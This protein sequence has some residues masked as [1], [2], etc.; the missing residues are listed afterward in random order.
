MYDLRKAVL[1]PRVP[2][3]VW[4]KKCFILFEFVPVVSE[5]VHL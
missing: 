3:F 2:F 4:H 1:F 5:W